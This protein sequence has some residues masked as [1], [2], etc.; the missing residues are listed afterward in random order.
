MPDSTKPV[1]FVLHDIGLAAIDYYTYQATP[2]KRLNIRISDVNTE[3]IFFGFKLRTNHPKW[4]SVLTTNLYM[5]LRDPLGNIVMGPQLVPTSTADNGFIEY[6]SQAVVGPDIVGSGG[7]NSDLS[8]IPSIPGDYYIE[9]NGNDPDNFL[10]PF[11]TMFEYFD[12]SVVDMSDSTNLGGRLWTNSL[13]LNTPPLA[14]QGNFDATMDTTVYLFHTDSILTSIEF[15]GMRALGFTVFTNNSGPNNTGDLVSDRQSVAGQ[16]ESPS[17]KVFVSFPDTTEF[18]ITG[19]VPK[20]IGGAELAGCNLLGYELEVEV[21]HNGFIEGYFDFNGNAIDDGPGSTDVRFIEN[22]ERGVNIIPWDGNDG[23]GNPIADGSTFTTYV[24]YNAGVTHL[25]LYDVEFNE[26]GFEINNIAPPGGVQD[27]YWDDTNVGG[28]DNTTVP[29][30]G[31]TGVCHDWNASFGNNRTINTWWITHFDFDTLSYT[32]YFDCQPVA[33]KDTVAVPKNITVSVDVQVND[34]DPNADPMTTTIVSGPSNGTAIISGIN[35][36]YTPNL[37]YEGPDTIYYSICDD[38]SP[39]PALCDTSFICL[40]VQCDDDGLD[41]DLEGFID[42]DGD[43]LNN[44]CD[45]DSDNDGITDADEGLEDRDG[46]GIP[47]FLD[48]DSDNDGIPD[49]IEANNGIAPSGYNPLTARII[50][51]DS[52]GDGL[53]DPVDNAPVTIYGPTSV[54]ILPNNDYDQDGLSDFLDRDSDNDGIL[55]VIEAG[56][57]DVNGN[58][59]I[60]GFVDANSDGA[61]DAVI[62]SPLPTLNTDATGFPNYIDT[63]S[64]GDGITD[65]REGQTTAAF[66]AIGAFADADNDGIADV[67]DR[68]LG[69][70]PIFPTDT[71][72]DG[73]PDYIDDDSDNDTVLDIIEGDDGNQDG[74]AAS[75]ALGLDADNDGL[76]DAFDADGGTL[77]GGYSNY[78]YQNTDG[79]TEPDWR[80]N[81]DDNDGV[82]TYNELTDTTPPNGIL[83]Y[84]ETAFCLPQQTP[85][86]GVIT[87]EANAIFYEVGVSNPNNALAFPDLAGAELR[88]GDTL[89]LTLAD[90][91]PSGE[92]ITTVLS[93]FGGSGTARATLTQSIDGI[94]FSNPLVYNSTVVTPSYE[95][96]PYPVTADTRYLRIVRNQRRVGVDGVF[97]SFTGTVC[98]PDKDEDGIADADDNDNDNDGLSDATEGTGDFDGDGIPNNCDLD[99]DNDGIP[100]AVEANNGVLPPN[101]LAQGK[102]PSSYVKLN[103][104]DSDGWASNT[105]DSE[106]G[107]NLPN[108]NFDGD[109]NPNFLDL[110]SDGDCIT[111]AVEG[112]GGSMPANMDNNGQ[113][114]V[115]Y[116]SANDDDGDGLIN[117]IDG[118]NLGL[119]LLVP[120]TDGLAFADFLDLD[121]DQDGVP[122]AQE[123]FD[124]NIAASTLDTDSDGLTDNCDPNN[125]GTAANLPDEDNDGTPDYLDRCLLTI[126]AGNWNDLGIWD[127]GR[128]PTCND[129]IILAHDVTLTGVEFASNLTIEAG[130][131]LNLNNQTLNLCGDL[132]NNGSISPTGKVNMQGTLSSQ[133]I[134]GNTTFNALSISNVNGVSLTAGTNINITDTLTLLAGNLDVTNGSITL[135]ASATT[136]AMVSGTGTGDFIGENIIQE[137]YVDGCQGFLSLGAPVDATYDAFT[138]VYYQGIPGGFIDTG[139]AN[140]YYYNEAAVGVSDSGYTAP[141]STSEVISQGTGF[142]NYNYNSMFD[143]KFWFTGPFRM[144]DVNLPV[145]YTPTAFG[146]NND[147]F[148]L[149]CNPYPATV[150]WSKTP[151]WT[152][153]GLCDAVYTWNRCINQYSSY[154]SGISVNGGT[155]YISPLSGFWVKAH[156]AGPLQLTVNRNA[157]VNEHQSFFRQIPLSILKVEVES[158]G[159]KDEAAISFGDT[160][161]SNGLGSWYGATKFITPSAYYP[162]LY[163]MQEF[164]YDTFKMAI[165]MMPELLTSKTVELQLKPNF[166]YEY[167][168]NFSE[169]ET[170]DE[171]ICITL[172]DTLLDSL[173]NIR[174]QPN[175]TFDIAD[176]NLTTRFK[177]HF[178]TVLQTDVI[179]ESCNE[180][181]DGIISAEVVSSTGLFQLYNNNGLLIAESQ[182]TNTFEKSQLPAGSYKITYESVAEVCGSFE[183]SI[184]VSEPANISVNYNI[185]QPTHCDSSDGQVVVNAILGGTEPYVSKLSYSETPYALTHNNLDWGNYLLQV[186]DTNGC[187]HQEVIEVRGPIHTNAYYTIMHDTVYLDD[188]NGI[189]FINNSIGGTYFEWDLGDGTTSTATDSIT[190]IYSQPGIYEIELYAL[191]SLC[192]DYFVRSIIVLDTNDITTNQQE[193]LLS[194]APGIYVQPNPVNS[195]ATIDLSSFNEPITSVSIIN[196]LGQ[197]INVNSLNESVIQLNTSN[198]SAGFHLVRVET[199]SGEV[200]KEKL[201]V[202]H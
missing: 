50:G 45:I 172:E 155:E 60:D 62:S 161:S 38:T 197:I 100:D 140:T 151:G 49:A 115:I 104:I 116:A 8:Y 181:N 68:D 192:D 75:T 149:V 69:N 126:A 70:S 127:L 177:L 176:T 175:Y 25:P 64:D 81:D 150:D 18:P 158:Y 108:G 152:K 200:Y 5:R 1:N 90:I 46:D 139:W 171:S 87:G 160:A 9:F 157:I 23:L 97:Y 186:T 59:E 183:K 66:L 103:D 37:D 145:Q 111:D 195:F 6:Y 107:T 48:L 131:N 20:I 130:I 164:S 189:T 174:A 102:Y 86:I 56:G 16:Q 119:P 106:G 88:G 185:N 84:F 137:R 180:N 156:Q 194:Q 57:T 24:K 19:G 92:T 30:D 165:N 154:V 182:N 89:I 118:D 11:W 101:M 135:S 146:N 7:Y 163:T 65:N 54:S 52:D 120:N 179:A 85:Q 79:D 95:S 27:V 33:L 26:N 187:Y 153:V 123:G 36:V 199:I 51:A 55:D 129:C 98:V 124:P 47:N 170:F 42:S 105:D 148:N 83:D 4:G 184:I 138:Y 142:I 178:N 43:G 94:N 193:L 128:V 143:Y 110:D 198:F 21:T 196:A 80:D 168:L 76:D 190:H 22:A 173:I 2:E 113:Y 201:I 169:Y 117:N 125:G 12:I 3:K 53:L 34:S 10:S 144:A 14:G 167:N 202:K 29:C 35:V 74:S 28:A 44:D 41:S 188:P 13:Y 122:D 78:A 109:A 72:S 82:L 114:P 191:D 133:N 61:F 17:H 99:S 32:L 77:F 121:S 58:G 112:N 15:D 67:Y 159:Y 91:V 166:A 162:S 39:A 132:A 147:G 71:D 73:N 31:L 96:F 134:T 40:D 136:T 141:L 93:R 63:D